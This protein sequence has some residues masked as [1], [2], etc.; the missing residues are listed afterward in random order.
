MAAVDIKL[1]T[2]NSRANGGAP[3]EVTD[4]AFSLAETINSTGAS[5]ASAIA[6]PAATAAGSLY[7]IITPRGGAVR[8]MFGPA[9]IAVDTAVGGWL[10]ADGIPRAFTARPGDKVA[11]INA[12]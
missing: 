1:G 11:I 6:A 5:Q 9:P 12:A 4:S 2:S 3:M 8:A 10:L 7:W